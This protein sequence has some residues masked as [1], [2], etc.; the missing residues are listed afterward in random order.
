MEGAAVVV[1][2]DVAVVVVDDDSVVVVDDVDVV[3]S[4][5]VDVEA[6]GCRVKLPE[7]I[8]RVHPSE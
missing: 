2:V 8:E 3:V 5:E 4:D 7:V 1:V 6:V